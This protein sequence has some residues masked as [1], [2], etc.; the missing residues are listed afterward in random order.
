MGGG[1]ERIGMDGV[2]L[3]RMGSVTLGRLYADGVPLLSVWF[4]LLSPKVRRTSLL[5]LLIAL[6]NVPRYNIVW[7]R[8]VSLAYVRLRRTLIRRAQ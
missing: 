4:G 7:V 1:V 5:V 2:G 8:C 3:V 6:K